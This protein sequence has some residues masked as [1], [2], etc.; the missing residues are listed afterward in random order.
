MKIVLLLLAASLPLSAAPAP[1][2][3]VALGDSTTA[4]TPAFR[5][6]LEAPPDGRGDVQSQYAYWLTRADPARRV[7]NRGINGQRAD[8]IRARFPRDVE[9][10]HP[11]FVLILAGV[12]DVYQDRPLA[13]AE[14]DLL[15]MYRR[16]KALGIIPV[17][18]SVL[19]FTRATP[20]QN[21]RL[22]ELNAWIRDAAA[23]EKI[24]FC[25]SARAVGD[26]KDP[27]RLKGSPDGLHP[28][29]AGYRA[30]GEA[31]AKT[32]ENAR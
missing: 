3:V 22:A 11:R 1:V 14:G 16:A 26:P 5:S 10:V 23:R 28:D 12:N 25:D 6:P 19:P 7:L 2:L 24:P 15:W 4:G 29:V 18:A 9:A 8:E 17:A 30:L 21:R 27:R 20:A 31:F 13:D 32:L